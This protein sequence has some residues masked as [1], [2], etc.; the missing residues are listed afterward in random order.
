MSLHR[1]HRRP[2]RRRVV[3]VDHDEGATRGRWLEME[4][5]YD[6]VNDVSGVSCARMVVDRHPEALQGHAEVAVVGPEEL[7]RRPSE[8]FAPD[9]GAVPRRDLEQ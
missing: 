5:G 6:D 7:K 8:G 3:Q 1:S 2:G 9:D 4:L